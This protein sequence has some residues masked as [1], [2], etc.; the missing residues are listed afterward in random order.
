MFADSNFGIEIAGKQ[1]GTK[2][3]LETWLLGV[4]GQPTAPGSPGLPHGLHRRAAVGLALQPLKAPQCLAGKQLQSLE[5][6]SS[7]WG[8]G[9]AP[10]QSCPGGTWVSGDRGGWSHGPVRLDP[11]SRLCSELESLP[12]ETEE[13]QVSCPRSSFRPVVWD[14]KPSSLPRW[15]P[16]L[17]HLDVPQR[18][19][20]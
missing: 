14:S 11:S 20:T 17:L 7:P 19:W 6:V 9:A 16:L 5:A 13:G 15:A 10:L 3:G 4:S 12:A 18:S 1:K 2:S 8:G